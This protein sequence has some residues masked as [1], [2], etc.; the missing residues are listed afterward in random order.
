MPH[1][2]LL[3]VYRLCHAYGRKLAEDIPD[4]RLAEQPL[5]GMNHPAWILG[6]LAFV[7]FRGEWLLTGREGWPVGYAELF[8]PGTA[9]ETDRSRYPSLVELLDAFDASHAALD[10]AVTAADDERW[11]APNP[12]PGYL[13][14]LL[15]NLGDMVAHIMST[16][17]ATHLG[18]LS[19]WRRAAGMPGVL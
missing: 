6:H 14:Q 11:A 3:N 7:G 10:A 18:Q 17:E 8:A 16:H 12:G 13:R 4:E 15:P 19:A 9:C 5:P 1:D 2:N